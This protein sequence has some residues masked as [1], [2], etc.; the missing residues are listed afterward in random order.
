[1]L[2]S[3]S[4]SPFFLRQPRPE[5]R[6]LAQRR[7]RHRAALCRRS[8]EVRA[9]VLRQ[10]LQD[11]ISLVTTDPA[12]FAGRYFNVGVTRARGL[13]LGFEARRSP[14]FTCTARLHAARLEDSR[15]RIARRRRVRPGHAAVSPAAAFRVR[16]RHAAAG[17]ALTADLNGVV[18]RAAS[19]TAT[20]ACSAR[21]SSRT[22]GTHT[23]D[24]RVALRLTRAAHRHRCRSTT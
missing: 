13:E 24:A 11:I 4:L 6:A 12:T 10:P 8:R 15:E 14:A 9:D 21:R 18:H 1:M 3:F 19:S 23:W 2:E 20:S 16:R 5:A 7:G 22:P 17:S